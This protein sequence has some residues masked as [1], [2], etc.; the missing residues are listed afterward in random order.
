MELNLDSIKVDK[1][2]SE[3]GGPVDFPEMRDRQLVA[4]GRFDVS[5]GTIVHSIGVSS[6]SVVSTGYGEVVFDN[7]LDNT[8]YTVVLSVADS[9]GGHNRKVTY[10]ESSLTVSGFLFHTTTSTTD[11]LTS[12]AIVDFA[13]L[14]GKANE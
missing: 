8:N 3:T 5:T 11:A 10:E 4:K 7:A 12:A 9:S 1:I 2:Y 6:I 14:G 13:I